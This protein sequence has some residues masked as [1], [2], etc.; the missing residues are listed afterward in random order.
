MLGTCRRPWHQ[1]RK[2]RC[3]RIGGHGTARLLAG[4]TTLRVV[5][6]R[7]ACTGGEAARENECQAT[8]IRCRH[9]LSHG[10]PQSR[11]AVARVKNL[12]RLCH[13]PAL[14][15]SGTSQIRGPHQPCHQSQRDWCERVGGKNIAGW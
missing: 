1:S 6:P 12:A 13:L 5:V 9:D 11:Q 10:Q 3:E 15:R 14:H 4:G 8:V 2:D 7:D